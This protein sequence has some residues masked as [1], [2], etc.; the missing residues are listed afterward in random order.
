MSEIRLVSAE[1]D[2]ANHIITLQRGTE[3]ERAEL[4]SHKSPKAAVRRVP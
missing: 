3:S 1:Q 4:N 2:G